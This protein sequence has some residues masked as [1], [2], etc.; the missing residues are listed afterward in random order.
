M[1]GVINTAIIHEHGQC[2]LNRDQCVRHTVFNA[3]G[4]HVVSVQ[5]FLRD[6]CTM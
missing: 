6:R 4:G 2:E 3:T 5:L 1:A